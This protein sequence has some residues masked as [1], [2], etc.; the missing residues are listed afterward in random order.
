METGRKTFRL[1]GRWAGKVL[2][3]QGA[4]LDYLKYNFANYQDGDLPSIFVGDSFS[5]LAGKAINNPTLGAEKLSDPGIEAWSDVNT[6]TGWAKYESGASTVTREDVDVHGGNYAAKL[7]IDASNSTAYIVKSGVITAGAWQKVSFWA[8]ADAPCSI[9]I[10]NGVANVVTFN[11][12]TEYQQF[13][14]TLIGEATYLAIQNN[15]AAN[16]IILID[17]GSVKNIDINTVTALIKKETD[18]RVSSRVAM[19]DKSCIGVSCSCNAA[20]NPTYGLFAYIDSSYIFLSKLVN[21]TWTNLIKSSINYKDDYQI[22]VVKKNDKVTLFYGGIQEGTTQIIT[23]TQIINGE[24]HGLFSTSSN[25]ASEFVYTTREAEGAVILTFDDGYAS[26]YSEAFSYMSGKIDKA[27][28]YV[29]TDWMNT[30]GF[31]N[32]SQMLEMQAGGWDIA[33]HTKTHATLT[34]Q[35]QEV[36]ESELSTAKAALDALGLESSNH[37]A[38]PGGYVNDTVRAAMVSTGMLTGRGTETSNNYLLKNNEYDFI[39]DLP[40]ITMVDNL[41]TIE[42]LQG[43]VDKAIT[44]KTVA[45]FYF[46]DIVETPT[47]TSE[48][49]ITLFRAF[50]D[51]VVANDVKIMKISELYQQL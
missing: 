18:Y 19:S 33:N 14:T 40:S 34:S 6:P 12:T 51:Y 16:R 10:V 7:N 4:L 45:I 3:K 1:A 44:N 43:Y 22:S 15:S 36:I 21:G 29:V 23:E 8:K 37:V 48:A 2:D 25:E 5:I 50:V 11:L 38:Y 47:I 42:E 32:T 9:K 13:S 46:H 26:A 20:D 31:V 24:F 28:L 49:S 30:A 27:T 35:T 41:S 39:Y 17:D